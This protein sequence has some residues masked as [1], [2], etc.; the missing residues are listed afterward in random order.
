MFEKL[1]NQLR[2]ARADVLR[3]DVEGSF[4]RLRAASADLNCRVASELANADRALEQRYGPLAHL[5]PGSK[6]RIA[7]VLRSL[8]KKSFD[9]DMGHGYALFFLGAYLESQTLSG[10]D[11]EFV[12]TITAKMLTLS[13]QV[14]ERAREQNLSDKDSSTV[15]EDIRGSAPQSS[16]TRSAEHGRKH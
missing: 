14:H 5:S 13:Q 12:Q 16:V 4:V 3:K 15:S 7:G 9:A 8:A 6:Q 10:H 1:R 2:E 11:A